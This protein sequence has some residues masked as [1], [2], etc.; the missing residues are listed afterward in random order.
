MRAEGRAGSAELAKGGMARIA[1]A[2][3]LRQTASAPLRKVVAQNS[4]RSGK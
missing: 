1:E 3:R 2:E 4:E